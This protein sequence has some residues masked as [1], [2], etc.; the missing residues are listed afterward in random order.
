MKRPVR[1]SR[2]LG[3]R[4]ERDQWLHPDALTSTA[5]DSWGRAPRALDH[6]AEVAR[7]ELERRPLPEASEAGPE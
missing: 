1:I 7:Y 4:K 2:L 3:R 6:N 5:S